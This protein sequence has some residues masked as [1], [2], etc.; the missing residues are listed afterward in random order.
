MEKTSSQDYSV[1]GLMRLQGPSEGSKGDP[2]HLFGGFV[3][4]LWRGEDGKG[5]TIGVRKLTS[6]GAEI[7][8]Y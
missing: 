6:Q 3:G 1:A 8:D 2:V 4:I 7:Q 5:K